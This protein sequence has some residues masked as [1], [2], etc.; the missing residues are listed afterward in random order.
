MVTGTLLGG[1]TPITYSPNDVTPSLGAGEV[2]SMLNVSTSGAGNG[3]YTLW[4]RG[5][6]G[7]PYLSV[8]Y[9][10]FAVNVG[11]V[12]RDFTT[13]LSSSEEFVASGA[14]VTFGLTIKRS[15]PAFGGAGVT[16]SLEALP[17][18]TLPTG[19]GAVSFSP[20][21]VNPSSSGTISTLTINSGTVAPGQYTLVIRATGM[22]G[23]SPGRQVTHLLPIRLDVASVLGRRQPAVRRHQRLAVM[24]VTQ[25]DSN[26]IQAYAI[27][28]V[29]ADLNDPQLRRGQVARLVPWN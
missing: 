22:N 2:V 3:I 18:E 11:S 12:S 27:T 8:K 10:P 21:N 14:D 9:K 4:L 20:N 13:S 16:L 25:G 24:R 1:A 23:D 6:A 7:S 19:L 17:G 5:E 26:T 15:G 29:I 28:P